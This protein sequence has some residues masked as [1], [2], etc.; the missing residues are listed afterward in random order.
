[1]RRQS[2]PGRKD[3]PLLF[4]GGSLVADNNQALSRSKTPTANRPSLNVRVNFVAHGSLA[5]RTV[6][7]AVGVSEK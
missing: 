4:S 1:L 7:S 5:I 6:Q 2:V 3:A